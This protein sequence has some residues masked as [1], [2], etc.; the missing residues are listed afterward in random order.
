MKQQN[1]GGTV[2][3]VHAGKDA[4]LCGSRKSWVS[5]MACS[6]AMSVIY[7][8]RVLEGMLGIDASGIESVTAPCASVALLAGLSL[9]AVALIARMLVDASMSRTPFSYVQSKRMVLL[10]CLLF[11]CALLEALTAV[12]FASGVPVDIV[13]VLGTSSRFGAP[14]IEILLIAAAFVSF[15]LSYIFNYG[16]FLQCF[17][18]ETV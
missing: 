3:N 14:N 15:Y 11:A 8:L 4:L 7:L 2:K 12:G 10:G 1:G 16:T 6:L 5:L 17:Y 18:D 13:T 9:T